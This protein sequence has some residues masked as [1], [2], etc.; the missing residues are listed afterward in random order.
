M[1]RL[2]LAAMWIAVVGHAVAQKNDSLTLYI[3]EQ[4]TL[5]TYASED[6]SVGAEGVVDVAVLPNNAL[7]LT[8]LKEGQT[9]ISLWNESGITRTW[10][11]EVVPDLHRTADAIKGLLA[12]VENIQVQVI[13]DKIIM[14]GK[15]LT[16]GD[17]ERVANVAN[18]FGEKSI[19]NLTTL[20][21]GPENALI[22]GFIKKMAGVDT[23][24]VK[25]TGST[26]Y[27]TGYVLNSDVKTRVLEIAKMQV[28]KVVD[29]LTIREVMID[30]EVMFI[31]M[32]K[33]KSKNVGINLLSADGSYFSPSFNLNG[34]QA[35]VN[36]TWSTLDM[37]IDWTVNIIPQLNIM[38]GNGDAR[39]L[40]RP[41]ITTKNGEK[42]YFQFGGEYYYEVS[43]VQVAELQQIQYGL[44][45]QVQPRF[46]RNDE[47]IND[48]RIDVKLPVNTA[49]SEKL[50][51]ET[52][53]SESS[54]SCRLGQ[55]I[56]LSGLVQNL[57]NML[58]QRTPILGD[59]PILN[60]FFG[61]TSQQDSDS[62][63]VAIITPRVTNLHSAELM[64]PLEERKAEPEIIVNKI[65]VLIEEID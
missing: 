51:L 34:Q 40:A 65:D 25:I 30:T 58:R 45:L 50:N 15:L 57:R 16:K 14:D 24:E 5:T 39:M 63:L 42:G 49:G 29:L 4:K 59:I 54:V 62:E 41:H 10:Q 9:E 43:G 55:S 52:F 60:L 21:R 28:E 18:A 23:I 37:S 27:L 6:I 46:G 12:D 61:N 44:M 56:V 11:V 19:V 53:T 13:G 47:V 31:K 8:G 3:G 35:R 26:A 64:Q 2:L 7:L 48:L 38:F 33:S 22:E 20:D 17:S 36:N 1:K 32:T